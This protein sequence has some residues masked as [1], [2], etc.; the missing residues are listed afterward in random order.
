MFSFGCVL[1]ELLSMREPWAELG[2]AA[3]PIMSKLIYD[4]K[5]LSVDDVP[6]GVRDAVPRVIDELRQCFS[7][8]PA[9]RPSAVHVHEVLEQA[10][11][12]L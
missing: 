2:G 12:S 3:F 1:W 9:A 4:K 8:D 7:F 10:I 5:A 6:K 11:E